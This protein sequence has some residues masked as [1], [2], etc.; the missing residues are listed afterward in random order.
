MAGHGGSGSPLSGAFWG[1]YR[2]EVRARYPDGPF[3]PS[4]SLEFRVRPPLWRRWWALAAEGVL[5][6]ALLYLLVRFRMRQLD[7]RQVR[8]EALVA[9]RT[10]ELQGANDTLTRVNDQ[11]LKLIQDLSSALSEVKTLRGLIPICSYCKKIRDDGGY[12][13]KLEQ[14]IQSRAEVRFSHG[15]CPDCEVQVREEMVQDGILPPAK[16]DAQT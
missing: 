16:G 1:G 6:C 7:R 11:N 2:F 15:I 13:N 3:G 10:E 8:L 5:G 4:A 14:Y 9:R 12:W